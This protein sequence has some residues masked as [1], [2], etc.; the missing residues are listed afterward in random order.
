MP[1][2]SPSIKNLVTNAIFTAADLIDLE[3]SIQS[4]RAITEDAVAIATCYVDTLEPGV[5]SWLKKL[6]LEEGRRQRAEGRR[7]CSMGR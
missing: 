3:K 1:V 7:N 2:L 5:G 6:L 4:G